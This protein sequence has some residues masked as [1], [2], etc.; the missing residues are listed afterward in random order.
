MQRNS[1][2]FFL[3]LFSATNYSYSSDILINLL[4][5]EAAEKLI[6]EKAITSIPKDNQ[7]I[8][9]MPFN[10]SLKSY[11]EEEK[12]NLNPSLFVESLNLYK[13]PSSASL[14]WTKE[15]QLALLNKSASLSSLKGIEYFSKSKGK[16]RVLY[17][18]SFV[19]DDPENDSIINN[20]VYSILP[21]SLI[22]FARQK[23]STFGENKYRYHYYCKPD[24]FI[25]TQENL[26]SMKFGFLTLIGANK[27][28]SI[29][30]VLDAEEYLVVYILSMANASPALWMER[31]IEQSFAN[32]ANA[33]MKWF[34]HCADNA[35]LEIEN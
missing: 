15:E 9:L 25:F 11:V 34:M 27:L 20:P 2:L 22:V 35:Y 17:E 3:F 33:V 23:D 21:D 24:I 19:I 8:G 30:A 26:T 31:R 5:K 16:M 6:K 4:G 28:R 7:S 10:P 1:L 29:I 18:E 14:R 13:K 32:R 12:V